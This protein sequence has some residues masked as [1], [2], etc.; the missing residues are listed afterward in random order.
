MIL[1]DNVFLESVV[2]SLKVMKP[3]AVTIARIEGDNAIQ[4]DV[5]S[6]CRCKI[7]NQYCPAHFTV[8]LSRGNG[9]S[10]IHQIA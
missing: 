1:L 4:P 7:R 9:S 2:S 10:E 3:I 5:Y 6:A 8:A